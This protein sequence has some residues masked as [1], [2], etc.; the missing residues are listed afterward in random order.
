[1]NQGN[2]NP[3]VSFF[4]FFII[5]FDKKMFSKPGRHQSR[6]SA[7]LTEP[8]VYGSAATYDSR[9]RSAS[10][11]NILKAD[12]SRVNH[13]HSKI[14]GCSSSHQRPSWPDLQLNKIIQA[15]IDKRRREMTERIRTQY[16]DQ[17]DYT[18]S[19]VEKNSGLRG[20]ADSQDG[21]GGEFGLYISTRRSEESLSPPPRLYGPSSG[22]LTPNT[23]MELYKG[24]GR[25]GFAPDGVM[26]S[27]VHPRH[28][29]SPRR[30]SSPPLNV[31]PFDYNTAN[32][33]KRGSMPV[34]DNLNGVD[35]TPD[36]IGQKTSLP[37]TSSGTK[38]VPPPPP[39]PL[40][41]KEQAEYNFHGRTEYVKNDNYIPNILQTPENNFN[42]HLKKGS[43]SGVN[44]TSS[45][46][47]QTNSGYTTPNK[48][49][50]Q[51]DNSLQEAAQNSSSNSHVR[52]KLNKMFSKQF[53]NSLTQNKTRTDAA[54]ADKVTSTPVP[55]ST[56]GH[57][58]GNPSQKPGYADV[59]HASD[60]G[61][62]H[63]TSTK[64]GTSDHT[65]PILS[66]EKGIHPFV[67]PKTS[68]DSSL[69]GHVSK[70]KPLHEVALTS[71]TVNVYGE[72]SSFIG[73]RKVD[74]I[75]FSLY[76]Y[77]IFCYPGKSV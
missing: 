28:V 41:R 14:S 43:T 12:S 59:E 10:C 47:F 62:P 73:I 51:I 75:C 61:H 50:S 71:P 7:D 22:R 35:E 37:K 9:K 20:F 8:S 26:S 49:N 6:S 52:E 24:S 18:F 69:K 4:H 70:F 21:D 32:L 2:S 46:E 55:Y 30:S 38:Y 13:V 40:P 64:H 33:T 57:H 42:F 54:G 25:Y 31:P 19:S 36:F 77:V 60:S 1:M 68:Q 45:S 53:S 29:L 15:E 5:F 76:T 11:E 34:L 44:S 39:P 17:P 58:S 65:S 72:V 63:Q 27:N 16:N 3:Q 56:V 48:N 23:G 66:A 67:T 74:F